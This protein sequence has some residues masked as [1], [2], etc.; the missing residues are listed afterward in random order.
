MKT[1][2]LYLVIVQLFYQF[3]THKL[4]NEETFEVACLGE[5]ISPFQA[6]IQE[7]ILK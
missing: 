1:S 2:V 6:Y 4:Q 5:L 3:V 7:F